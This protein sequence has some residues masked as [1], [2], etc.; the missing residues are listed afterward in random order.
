MPYN[1]Y[2]ERITL[3]SVPRRGAVATAV[4]L[5]AFV[6]I[7]IAPAWLG[8]LAIDQ[9]FYDSLAR[10][11]WSPPLLV[12][13][14]AWLVVQALVGLGVWQVWRMGPGVQRR[15]AFY[16][17]LLEIAAASVWMPQLFG[18]Q[19]TLRGLLGAA[20]L[21]VT[22]GGVLITGAERAPR[23]GRYLIPPFLW[24]AYLTLM[25]TALWTIN[26]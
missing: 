2:W 11:P 22:T 5:I 24:S 19:S 21:L 15:H 1:E 13:P 26:L 10:G 18:A 9:E 25:M 12:F 8:A 20:A 3:S 16:W 23:A 6:A 4:A 14:A 17:W 7:S